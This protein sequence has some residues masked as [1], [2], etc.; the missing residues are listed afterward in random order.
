MK[1]LFVKTVALL[2]ILLSPV[3][4]AQ[5]FYGTVTYESKISF[6]DIDIPE[7]QAQE[8][9]DDI[10]QLIKEQ[11]D[12]A[13]RNTYTLNFNKTSSLY[14]QVEKPKSLE[15]NT[16]VMITT[17]GDDSKFYTNLKDKKTVRQLTGFD[18][19]FI[20]TDSIV[21]H[22]WKLINETKKIGDYTCYKA[23]YTISASDITVSNSLS[24]EESKDRIVTA[25]YTKQ[26]PVQ[27]GPDE[28]G[29]L[30]GLIL[31]LNNE[32]Q[33]ILCSKIVLN[34]KEKPEIIAPKKGKKVT[35]K[36]FEE[37]MVKKQE[38]LEKQ[39]KSKNPNN[40]DGVYFEVITN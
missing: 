39:F 10:Q 36:E 19:Q 9:P 30:P 26:I 12:N 20:I 25:W 2:A 1:K 34:P 32:Q 24:N 22:P 13:G 16:M 14:E 7:E 8:L 33:T 27:F 3:L 11:L 40:K 5:D 35:M 38:E 6:P 15:E 21:K 31:E 37:I 28:Y 4:N 18:K 29:G 23:T 17:E